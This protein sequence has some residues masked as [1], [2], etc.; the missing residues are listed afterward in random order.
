T[1][2]LIRVA[3]PSSNAGDKTERDRRSVAGRALATCTENCLQ[4]IVSKECKAPRFTRA[5][6]RTYYP[7]PPSGVDRTTH[8]ECT[9][10]QAIWIRPLGRQ[11]GSGARS[12]VE[13]KA[14]RVFRRGRP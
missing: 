13:A 11:F 2:A 5:H 3:G 6:H 14:S 9:I 4:S 10:P 7:R 8:R 12:P 1:I